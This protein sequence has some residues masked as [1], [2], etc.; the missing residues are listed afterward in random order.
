M[1]A[2]SSAPFRPP[3][4]QTAAEAV[5]MHEAACT[6]AQWPGGTRAGSVGAAQLEGGTSSA[7]RQ[8]LTA[9][10]CTATPRAAQQR[11]SVCCGVQATC[12][13]RPVPRCACPGLSV[14]CMHAS[15]PWSAA[16]HCR[17]RLPGMW[18]YASGLRLAPLRLHFDHMPLQRAA[19]A[20]Q[21]RHGPPSDEHAPQ[22]HSPPD[23]SLRVARPLSALLRGPAMPHSAEHGTSTVG[24]QAQGTL[25]FAR[26]QRAAAQGGAGVRAAPLG[27]CCTS[28][29]GRGSGGFRRAGG[30]VRQGCRL[31]ATPAL[32][33]KGGRSPVRPAPVLL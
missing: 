7:G 1:L 29:S 23:R 2:W 26:L 11:F 33:A 3:P 20:G 32:E 8:A 18:S 14:L 15:R 27:M 10:P 16:Q 9:R 25:R 28:F 6:C 12:G 30:W 21:V 17:K 31:G 13:A 5:P 22:Q 24:G 19:G 4:T